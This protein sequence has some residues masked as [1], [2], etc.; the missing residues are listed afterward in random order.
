MVILNVKY[1]KIVK[2]HTCNGSSIYNVFMMY[3]CWLKYILISHS[4]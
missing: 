4:H 3:I 1:K 2:T